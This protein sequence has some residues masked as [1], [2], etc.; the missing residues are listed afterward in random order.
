[1]LLTRLSGLLARAGVKASGWSESD[2]PR[3][4][5]PRGRSAVWWMGSTRRVAAFVN[6]IHRAVSE[7]PAWGWTTPAM[8]LTN[9][10]LNPETGRKRPRANVAGAQI[11]AARRTRGANQRCGSRE[12]TASCAVTDGERR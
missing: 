11:G 4:S 9:S 8:L 5:P 6:Y 12:N 7:R 2:H 3:R 10:W 1:M